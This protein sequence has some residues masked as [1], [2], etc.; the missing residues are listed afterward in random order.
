MSGLTGAAYVFVRTGTTWT[1]QAALTA[2]DGQSE[3]S[4]GENSVAISGNTAIAGADFRNNQTGAAY[5][6]V[7]TSSTWA[8]KAEFTDPNGARA[9]SLG[10]GEAIAGRT[11]LVGAPGHDKFHGQVDLF[12]L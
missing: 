2:S 8:Q 5:E 9:D 10:F 11:A 4:L 6:F 1:Q 3:D 7:R 12:N